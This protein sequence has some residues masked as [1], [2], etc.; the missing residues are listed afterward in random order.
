MARSK[1]QKARREELARA[2]R[3]VIAR[4]GLEG[5]RLHR[6]AEEV[7]LSPGAVLY[8]YPEIDDLLIEAIKL[9]FDRFDAARQT[10]I[11]E[12]DTAAGRLEALVRHGLPVDA[13]DLDVRVFCQ[14]G[15]AAGENTLAATMLTSL[16]ERQ[17]AIY[18]I[19]LEQ[20]AANGEFTLG[21]PSLTVARNIVALE[22]AYGYRIV[23]GHSTIDAAVATE[24]ILDY[25]GLA[26]GR[27]FA[28]Q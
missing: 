2:A 12:F 21:S 7:N 22:D 5:A 14:L 4:Y 24:L 8:Y 27:R 13:N 1:N 6:I 9:G 15:G 23:A 28:R 10:L 16:Y 26:T 25:A 18:Q 17:V 19:V 11:T 3:Q 20:G